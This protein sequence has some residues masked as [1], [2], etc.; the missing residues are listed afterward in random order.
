M[1]L[2][3][4]FAIGASLATLATGMPAAAA[5][6][7]VSA[8]SAD[9]MSAVFDVGDLTTGLAPVAPVAGSAP[10]AYD[11]TVRLADID[12]IVTIIPGSTPVVALYAQASGIKTHAA[13]Q[14]LGIDYVAAEG[15]AS[16]KSAGLALNLDPP[17]PTR[18]GLPSPQPFLQVTG[19]GITVHATFSQ[20]IPLGPVVSSTVTIGSLTVGGSLLGSK[21]LKFSG[22]A[23]PGTVLFQSDTV[24]VTLNRQI[25]AGVISCDVGP[26]CHFVV[27]SISAD[28]VVVSLSN[29]VIRGTPVTG[30][31]V[32]GEAGA[33]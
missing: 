7:S 16:L 17:P 13:S 26:S 5:T 32:V 3:K 2:H 1:Q 27:S 19:S 8:S 4:Y 20:T 31:I 30:D 23:A 18:P 29:A 21:L 6:A 11:K 9:A 12:K 24:T 10:P 15:D 22:K 25:V 14:G 33:R 28:A